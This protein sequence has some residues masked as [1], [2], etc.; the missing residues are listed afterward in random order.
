MKLNKQTKM[1]LGLGVVALGGYLVWKQT[2][3]KS[4]MGMDGCQSQFERCYSECDKNNSRCI[5][6]CRM[7]HLDC[8]RKSKTQ[9]QRAL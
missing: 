3:K 1:L 4:F 9:L 6:L 7:D 2:Q 5:E 8:T